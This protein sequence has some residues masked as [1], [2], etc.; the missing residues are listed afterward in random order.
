MIC[1]KIIEIQ[2]YKLKNFN[3]EMRNETSRQDNQLN[4]K[5]NH[6]LQEKGRRKLS[7]LFCRKKTSPSSPVTASF[8]KKQ[9]ICPPRMVS[10]LIA[11]S[12]RSGF[13]VASRRVTSV[14]SRGAHIE[15]KMY[16]NS[17]LLSKMWTRA[18][19]CSSSLL[20]SLYRGEKWV[21]IKHGNSKTSKKGETLI[22]FA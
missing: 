2:E 21:T 16:V 11:R 15:N 10:Q 1:T 18:Q 5:D 6:H 22:C 13:S 20:F 19:N 9:H 3:K 4:H 7:F 12:A 17:H 8:T 14:P